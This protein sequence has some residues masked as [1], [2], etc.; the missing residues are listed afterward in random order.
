MA[1]LL[2]ICQSSLASDAAVMTLPSGMNNPLPLRYPELANTPAPASIKE[3]LR[4]TYEA[5]TSSPDITTAGG[6]AFVGGDSGMGLDQVDVVALEGGKAATWTTAFAPDPTTNALKKVNFYGSVNPEGC[7]DF[8]CNPDI[9]RGIPNQASEDLVV[10]RGTYDIS[11]K[12]YNI[13]RF[14]YKSPQGIELG[15]I[16]DLETGI[17][18]HHTADFASSFAT[19]EGGTVTRQNHAILKLRNLRQVNIPWKKGMV[20]SWVVP[21]RLLDFQGQHAF[22]LPQLPNAAPT[23]SP[24]NVKLAIQAVHERFVEGKQQSYTQ[25]PIQPAYVPM[26]CG[27][28]QLM[29]FWVPQEALSLSPGVIDSDPDTGMIVS[30][31]DSGPEGIVMEE[32]N[33]VNYKLTAVYDASGKAIRTSTETYSGTA[34]GQRDDLQLVE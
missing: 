1:L 19:E 21:G 31:I 3:G 7:G 24:L 2:A 23:L 17:M 9:L 34:T 22:W 27:L 14:Y 25:E 13:I 4:A 5:V 6:L 11:G 20:P 16:Y 15:M 12:Q 18:L 28:A 10:D 26:V 8:W 30:V 32:T 29:G 33:N